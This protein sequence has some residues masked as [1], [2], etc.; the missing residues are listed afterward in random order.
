MEILEWF[1]DRPIH[2]CAAMM[3]LSISIVSVS[4]CTSYVS[5]YE[6]EKSKYRYE[7]MKESSKT[8]WTDRK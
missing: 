6:I 2:F 1:K 3:F 7:Y 8:F 4:S 5:Y